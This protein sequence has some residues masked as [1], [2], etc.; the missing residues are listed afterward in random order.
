M[1]YE[2]MNMLDKIN[3]INHEIEE[4][5][6]EVI[7]QVSRYEHG[8]FIEVLLKDTETEASVII[9]SESITG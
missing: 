9:H 7:I 5:N 6:I 1:H 3:D 2:V 4:G 8:D